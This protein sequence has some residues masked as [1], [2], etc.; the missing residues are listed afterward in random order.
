MTIFPEYT[1]RQCT[2]CSKW[3]YCADGPFAEGDRTKTLADVNHLNDEHGDVFKREGER[4]WSFPFMYWNDKA[5]A[6]DDDGME[7]TS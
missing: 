3:V 1:A 7:I 2:V 4:V 5:I 6:V